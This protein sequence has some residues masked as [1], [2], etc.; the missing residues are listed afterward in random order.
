[1][2]AGGSNDAIN[3]LERGSKPKPCLLPPSP[4]TPN[5]LLWGPGYFCCLHVCHGGPHMCAGCFHVCPGCA[6]MFH[7]YFGGTY[8]SC[9]F[10]SVHIF[11]LRTCS[12]TCLGDACTYHSYKHACFGCTHGCLGYAHA[13]SGCSC[14]S[15]WHPCMSQLPAPM[16]WLP[17]CVSWLCPHVSQG[18]IHMSWLPPCMSLLPTCVL[19]VHTSVPLV[20][21]MC[22]CCPHACPG[23][24]HACPC[25]PH[26]CPGCARTCPFAHTCVLAVHTHV[27]V[28]LPY[29]PAPRSP[30]ARPGQA[31]GFPPRAGP[32]R[33]EP[34]QGR[35]GCGGG[36]HQE[37][38]GFGR[39]FS[40][41]SSFDPK[42][43]GFRSA[44][45]PPSQVRPGE[46]GGYPRGGWGVPGG[47]CPPTGQA[48]PL[49]NRRV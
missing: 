35:A 41:F 27:P 18:A 28:V 4:L 47:F 21:P 10:S 34:R 32:H 15:W 45:H 33:E 22:P 48:P 49:H 14:M 6:H 17:R 13:C 19:T 7:V 40:L 8:V 9:I 2:R 23:W 38:S 12:Y 42:S 44:P 26:A 46:G 20:L 5:W 24:A 11:S 39:V 3:C 43:S 25:C 29:G 31:P 30:P 16:S 37:V 1:M 36:S